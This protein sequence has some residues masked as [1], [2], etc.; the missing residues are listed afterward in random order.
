MIK[1]CKII[2]HNEKNI[3]IDYDG[4]L[5]QLPNTIGKNIA[6]VYVKH[7]NDKYY[8]VTKEEYEKFHNKKNKIKTEFNKEESDVL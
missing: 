7:H 3:V 4:I 2:L 5:V 6:E 1:K 8:I